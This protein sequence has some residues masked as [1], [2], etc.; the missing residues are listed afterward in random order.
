MLFSLAMNANFEL[1]LSFR[2]KEVKIKRQP[3]GK[4]TNSKLTLVWP[5]RFIAATYTSLCF[6][7]DEVQRFRKSVVGKEHL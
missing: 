5:Q 7:Q 3:S 6:R 2:K 4:A 1:L